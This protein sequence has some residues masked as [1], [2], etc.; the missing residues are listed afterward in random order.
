MP[1]TPSQ[2]RSPETPA[3]AETP[4]LSLIGLA[5][6]KAALIAGIGATLFT[7]GLAARVQGSSAHAQ[8]AP[9]EHT[10][11]QN[12]MDSSLVFPSIQSSLDSTGDSM[13]KIV[14][15]I[16]ESIAKNSSNNSIFTNLS[17]ISKISSNDLKGQES[18]SLKIKKD[19]KII[20]SWYKKNPY[21]L[22]V[23]KNN[24]HNSSKRNIGKLALKILGG[25][26]RY[27]LTLKKGV[28][29]KMLGAYV[30]TYDYSIEKDGH[31]SFVKSFWK[32]IQFKKTRTPGKYIYKEKYNSNETSKSYKSL[33]VLFNI[34]W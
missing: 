30:S 17:E 13:G 14:N 4:H 32:I 7:G 23:G 12:V 33:S 9:L 28:K 5:R 2:P 20:S 21:E 10:L 15:T 22:N 24:V 8:S 31:N 19:K 27:T 18:T 1:P 29:D 3:I 34:D 26:N 6:N 25:K 16:D 11:E